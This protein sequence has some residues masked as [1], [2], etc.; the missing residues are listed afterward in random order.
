MFHDCAKK[1]Y[2]YL[3]KAMKKHED[4]W[5]FFKQSRI[6]NPSNLPSLDHDLS[7]YSKLGFPV[8]NADFLREWR[9]YLRAEVYDIQTPSQLVEFWSKHAGCLADTA[10]FIVALPV[11]SA[12]VERSFSLMGYVDTKLRSGLSDE[13]RKLTSMLMRRHLYKFTPE[14][15]VQVMHRCLELYNGDLEGR[16]AHA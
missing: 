2:E 13:T 7:K 3:D 14:I 5:V 11:T 9:K 12:D 6:L 4:Q 8:D 1:G 15:F 10:A 16:F